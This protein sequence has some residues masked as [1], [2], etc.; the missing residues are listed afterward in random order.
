MSR[1]ILDDIQNGVVPKT[2]PYL[3]KCGSKLIVNDN[4]TYIWCENSNCIFVGS[5]SIKK[6]FRDLTM[7]TNIGDTIATRLL[8]ELDDVKEPMDIFTSKW[9]R[10]LQEL[11]GLDYIRDNIILELNRVNNEGIFLWQLFSSF[12]I[13]ALASTRCKD[14]FTG[15]SSVE[16]FY[17]DFNQNSSFLIARKLNISPE[18]DTIYSITK[19]LQR[20]ENKIKEVSKLFKIKETT[21]KV[22]NIA[23]TG[24]IIHIMSED[25]KRIKNRDNLADIL[26]NMYGVTVN[27][28]KPKND[29][30]DWLI[31]DEPMQEHNKFNKV[32][33]MERRT[34]RK[35]IIT[36]YEFEK[37]INKDLGLEMP[38]ERINEELEKYLDINTYKDTNTYENTDTHKAEWR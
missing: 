9:L 38:R 21:D 5:K 3:C 10:G 37:M 30:F 11:Q 32:S 1:F 27:I 4:N 28:R 31:M 34:G 14:I 19:E 18:T 33:E 2:T 22:Y 23:I 15:Y 29:N 26:Y 35:I 8:T 24:S 17:N 13:D 20:L 7:Y 12:D 36:S 6:T 25:G 16:E